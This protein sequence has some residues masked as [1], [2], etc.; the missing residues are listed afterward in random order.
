MKIPKLIEC[1]KYSNSGIFLLLLHAPLIAQ[2]YML[3]SDKT[4]VCQTLQKNLVDKSV[5]FY[6]ILSIV[7]TRTNQRLLIYLPPFWICISFKHCKGLQKLSCICVTT[8]MII[9]YCGFISQTQT[10]I[11]N[12][13]I[14]LIFL[15]AVNQPVWCSS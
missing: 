3:S 13:K 15:S 14:C 1:C 12:T 9:E 5:S 8:K 10:F 4:V 7:L 2:P 6:C 11:P